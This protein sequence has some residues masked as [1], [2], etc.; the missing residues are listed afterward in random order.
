MGF[1]ESQLEAINHKDGPAL[2]LAGPGS[3]KTTVICQRIKQLITG[4]GVPPS[5]ILVITFTKAAAREMKQRFLSL[6]GNLYVSVTFGTFHAVFFS[7]LCHAYHYSVNSIITTEAQFNFIR[8]EVSKLELEFEDENEGISLILS[9]IS[10][11]KCDRLSINSYEAYSCPPESFKRIFKEYN[12]MLA[13][14][15]LIDFDDMVIMCYDLL[16]KNPDYLMAWQNKYRYILIDEFQDINS[17]QFETIKLISDRFKNVFVVG[18]DDQSIYGF[19]G[20]KPEIMLNFEKIYPDAKH[21]ELNVNYRSKKDIIYAAKSVIDCNKVRFYKNFKVEQGEGEK[22][23]ICEFDNLEE[24]KNFLVSQIKKL[25]ASGLNY[26]DIGIL[27]RTNVINSIYGTVLTNEGIPCSYVA[28][29]IS[30]YDYWIGKDIAAYLRIAKGSRKRTDFLQIVNKPMRYITR[31]FLTEPV[32]FEKLM[33]VYSND[34]EMTE[35]I[36]DFRFDVNMIRKMTPFAALNYIRKAVG[37]DDYIRDYAG[38]HH[39]SKEEVGGVLEEL[40]RQ[41]KK[42]NTSGQWLDYMDGCKKASKDSKMQ[43]DRNNGSLNRRDRDGVNFY[44]FHGAKGLEFRAVFITDVC[45]GIVPYHKAVLDSEIEEERRMFYVAMTRAKEKL[46][47]CYPKER[48]NKS[49]TKSRFITEIDESRTDD[50]S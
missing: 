41:A 38:K 47:L 8:N 44:T 18:D 20:S 39:I 6:T 22:V 25:H 28:K 36:S 11:V 1:N 46:Y 26:S 17:A 24:E 23:H 15:R 50:Y 48:Y 5:E 12:N 21:I 4:Y 49:T 3:G 16:S 10:R 2:V 45:E 42:F 37:Y 27:S 32:S 34:T 13:N 30:I 35:R 9:E 29:E 19:R 40:T 43:Q 33:D 14:K 31:S 7:I